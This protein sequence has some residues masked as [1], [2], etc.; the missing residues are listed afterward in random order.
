MLVAVRT[1]KLGFRLLAGAGSCPFSLCLCL[2]ELVSGAF[3]GGA[4]VRGERQDGGARGSREGSDTHAAVLKGARG[5]DYIRVRATRNAG[6]S[7]N[8]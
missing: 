4:V 7:R 2:V 3:R 6:N 8:R 5:T 1:S